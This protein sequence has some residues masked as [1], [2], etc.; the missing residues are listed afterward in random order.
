M[1]ASLARGLDRLLAGLRTLS[2]AGIWIGGGGLLVFS[3]AVVVEVLMRR[4]MN[5]SFAGLDELGGY[6]LAIVGAIAFTETLLHRGHIRIDVI[7]ARVGRRLQ[8][9]LDVLAMLG[10]IVFFGTM[11]FYAQHLLGRSIGLQSR[12]ISSLSVILWVPQSIWF[13][14]IALFVVTAITLLARAIVALLLG[15]R[16]TAVALIGL[17][18]AEEELAEEVELTA[19]ALGEEH[20]T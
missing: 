5:H 8:S 1:I 15:D 12:S 9:A 16:A 7:H 13:V 11:L 6:M 2:S 17:R 18:S 3:F 14:G 19:N 20:R 4:F 10:V